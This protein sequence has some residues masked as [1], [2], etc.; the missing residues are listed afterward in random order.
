MEIILGSGS[1]RRKELLK[2]LGFEFSVMISDIDE[3][4][5]SLMPAAD[6]APFLA[7]LK[8]NA[9]KESIGADQ[10]LICCDTVVIE[11]NKILGKPQ[12]VSEAS[13]TLIQL[14]GKK[15]KV[16]SAVCLVY[17]N[18]VIE[19]NDTTE[20]EFKVFS[21]EEIDYYIKAYEP[22]DKAG[23]YGIQEWIGHIGA[24]KIEGSYT[25]VMGLP[26]HKL[27][28]EIKKLKA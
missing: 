24:I 18:Q 7:K 23:S 26:T 5:D 12:D 6:V 20:I 21:T 15:H 19:F 8:S 10:L 17:N 16:M 11:S 22:Y 13:R 28:Q 14:S 27:Y 9:L 3:S 1:P 2:Q 4:F 25:N